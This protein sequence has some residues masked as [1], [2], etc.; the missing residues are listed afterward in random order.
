[1]QNRA[2]PNADLG[3]GQAQGL[4][5]DNFN[6]ILHLSKTDALDGKDL[7]PTTIRLETPASTVRHERL[8]PL[9]LV[10]R[11]LLHHTAFW[12]LYDFDGRVA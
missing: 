7:G 9:P 5:G 1:M 6:V 4:G 11:G 8:W 12:H 2:D 3:M 10:Y